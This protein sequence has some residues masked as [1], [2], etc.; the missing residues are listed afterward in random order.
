MVLRKCLFV[1]VAISGLAWAGVAGSASF[2]CTRAATPVE[3][4]ICD[5]PE[6]NRLDS[7]M[8]GLYDRLRDELAAGPRDQ[9]V[10]EQKGW[11][12]VRNHRC[13]PSVVAMPEGF[14]R[15]METLYNRRIN[16]LN[17]EL[18]EPHRPNYPQ[19]NGGSKVCGNCQAQGPDAAMGC[20]GYTTRSACV[21]TEQCTWMVKSCP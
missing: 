17:A 16:H 5:I 11:L 21:G 2:D 15:C 9:L 18:G 1:F 19:N 10:R 6:I 3:E 12:E 13:N 14:T 20:A 7:E 8:G 4:G